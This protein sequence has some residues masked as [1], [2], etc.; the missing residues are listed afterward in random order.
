V[1]SFRPATATRSE[2]RRGAAWVEL[3]PHGRA[4]PGEAL[5]ERVRRRQRLV[6]VDVLL[7][8]G[9]DA[10]A[11]L[12]GH[13]WDWLEISPGDIVPVRPLPGRDVSA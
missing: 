7:A 10:V 5:V 9:S 1:S 8:D 6:E 13:D 3:A 12:D 2:R 4:A 11:R